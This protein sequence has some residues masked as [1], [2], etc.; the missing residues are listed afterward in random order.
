MKASEK[1]KTPIRRCFGSEQDSCAVSAIAI[2]RPQFQA[3][4]LHGAAGCN[5]HLLG[6]PVPRNT[7]VAIHT[8]E[9]AQADREL[10]CF[11]P[12]PS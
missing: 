10:E 9:P 6:P 3:I 1:D 4:S 5:S 12:L 11:S 2:Q 7:A 8:G